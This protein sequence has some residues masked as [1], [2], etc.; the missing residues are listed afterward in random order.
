MS[1]LAEIQERWIGRHWATFG[2]QVIAPPGSAD[3]P[4]NYTSA[5]IIAQTQDE[6][7]SSV[8]AA[9]PED[10]RRL[11]AEVERLRKAELMAGDYRPKRGDE[12]ETWLL[13]FRDAQDS[14]SSEWGLLDWML[15]SY[16]LH[17]DCG[18]SLLE[19]LGE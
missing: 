18:V 7:I 6:D 15:E 16:R 5:R 13:R 12:V 9:A 17:A 1:D 2:K 4:D 11:I 14:D 10:V 8:I 3:C 19:D